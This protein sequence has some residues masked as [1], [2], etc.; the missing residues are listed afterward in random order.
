VS[1]SSE[2]HQQRS[3]FIR[4]LVQ[5][6]R[7]ESCAHVLAK[8]SVPK[9]IVQYWDNHKKLPRDVEECICSWSK[10]TKAGYLH[11]IFDEHA[12][13]EFIV[14]ALGKRH[15]TAFQNCYHPAMQADYF[16]LCYLFVKG[17][18]YVDAD[19]I[20]IGREIDWLFSDSRL[21]LQPLCYDIESNSMINPKVFLEIS[22]YS[23]SWIFYVNNNPLASSSGHPIIERALKQA[24]YA[25]QTIDQN[26][27][28]EIQETTGPGNLSKAIFD[29]GRMNGKLDKE[30]MVLDD[31]DSIA[32]S[33]WPLSYRDDA[34]NWRHSNRISFF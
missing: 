28:P 10:W 26:S 25:L 27:L 4:S 31:W 29:L 30:L 17:G 23:P 5:N 14:A 2:N 15:G 12:A 33:K 20:C 13:K 8:T 34:R 9:V 3:E 11:H 24:T 19:D 7:K 16:R 1:T 18:L 32:I 6:P 21:K 22:A